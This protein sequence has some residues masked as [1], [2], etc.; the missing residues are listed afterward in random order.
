M[1]PPERKDDV[2]IAKHSTVSVIARTVVLYQQ[3]GRD[4]PHSKLA[5]QRADRQGDKAMQQPVAHRLFTP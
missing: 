3:Q 5:Q 1:C 2:A 4:R